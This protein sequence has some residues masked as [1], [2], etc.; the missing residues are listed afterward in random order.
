MLAGRHHGVHAAA[1]QGPPAT[2]GCCFSP[3]RYTPG[4]QA[5]TARRPIRRLRRAAQGAAACLQQCRLLRPLHRNPLCTA[6]CALAHS[7]CTCPGFH[8]TT[9]PSPSSCGW[10][11]PAWRPTRVRRHSPARLH[12]WTACSGDCL[13]AYPPA[14]L[15]SYLPA[16]PP[17][18]PPAAL[19][20]TVV[21]TVQWLPQERAQ[22]SL[23]PPLPAH[24]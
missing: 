20:C 6:S 4:S 10:C 17:A 7:P 18:G 1:Q 16:C 23:G 9:L 21:H 22:G 5:A 2:A 11:A 15:P 24:S 19:D 13:P 12:G 14:R 3:G 8:Q